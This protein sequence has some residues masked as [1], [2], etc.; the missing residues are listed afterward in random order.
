MSETLHFARNLSPDLTSWRRH[1]HAHPETAFEE[2]ETTAYV[3]AVLERLGLAV[4]RNINRTG[5]LA[6]LRVPGAAATVALRADIDALPMADAKAVPYRSTRPGRGHMCGHDAHTAM[7]LGAATLLTRLRGR[8]RVNVK[9]VFQPSEERLPGGAKGIVEAGLLDDV[10]EILA[11]HVYS[12][13]PTGTV[14]VR[15]GPFLASADQFTVRFRAEGGHAAAPHRTADP[16]VASADFVTAAQSIVA[17]NVD[18]LQPAVVSVCRWE[19]GTADNVIPQEVLLAG[20]VRALSEAVRDAVHER[21]RSLVRGVSAA[22]GVQGDAEIDRGYP[23]TVNHP[24]SVERVRRCAVRL[25]GDPRC[26]VDTEPKCGS[27]DFAYYLQR[28]P[29]AIVW[30][31][32]G[33]PARGSHHGHHHPLFDVDEDALPLGAALLAEFCLDRV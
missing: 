30:L 8:L 15:A 28:L 1:L 5:V 7:A 2:H 24:A 26:V 21:L 29:G 11:L 27:E 17:R 25:L 33:N 19:A 4:R 6:E 14:G 31:G 12:G 16:V 9:F 22:H 32:S 20:T 10:S 23:V 13:L 18:P 3:A